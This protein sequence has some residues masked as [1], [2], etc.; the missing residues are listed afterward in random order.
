MTSG[1]TLSDFVLGAEGF[2]RELIQ[3]LLEIASC[4]RDISVAVSTA[5][6]RGIVGF[7]GESNVHGER[8]VA[9]DVE[10]NDILRQ[11]PFLK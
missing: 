3:L 5:K 10:A 9:L 8:Q 6:I 7:T 1:M 2:D 4:C 11:I